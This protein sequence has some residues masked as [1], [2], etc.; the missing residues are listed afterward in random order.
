QEV[1]LTLRNFHIDVHV[2]D[3]FARTTIDQTYFNN[4]SFRME[5]TFYFPLPP[6]ASLSRLAMYVVDGKDCKLME[7]GMAERDHA[8][9][10]FE[11]IMHQ[12][13]D[14][15]LL[16]WVDGSTFKMR[17][18]PL[19][20]RQE[21]RII[22][23]YSQRL[24]GLY[25]ATRYRFPA[26]H[27]MEIVRDWSFAARVKH[28]A[29]LRVTSD[30]HP[31]MK[32]A[33]QAADMVLT[34]AARGVKP[35]QDVTVEI[36][37]NDAAKQDNVAR[38][39]SYVHEGHQYLMLNYRPDLG[40]TPRRERRDWIILFETAANRDPLLAR[41]QIEV[42]KNLLENA[43]HDDN[44]AIL[45]AN[46][47]VKV[48]DKKL[49]AVNKQNIEE[50]LKYLDASHLIGAL[51]LTKALAAAEPFY[52]QA[53]N[54]YLVHV[55]AGVS[56]L[57]EPKEDVLAKQ[58]PENV[59]YVGIG[60]GKRWSRAFMKMAADRTGG[61]FT[62]I[63]P[64]EPIAWRTFELLA[65]LNTP[66]WMDV[67]VIDA[68]EKVS[69]LT[70]TLSLAQGE[71]L[72]AFARFQGP[73]PAKVIV[74]GRLDGKA[75]TQTLEVKGVNPG[76]GYLPRTWAKMEIDRLLADGAE[77][78]KK[79]I[80]DLSMAMY[81]MSPFTSLLVLETEQD[82]VTYKVDRGRKDHWAMYDCPLR[83]PL[84]YEPDP[85]QQAWMNPWQNPDKGG[86][87]K[88]A[89]EVLGSILMRNPPRM[90]VWPN[91][92]QHHLP[93]Y[94][95]AHQLY[96]GQ[97]GVVRQHMWTDEFESLDL[98][99]LG[100]SREIF[101][102]RL[103]ANTDALTDL[104]TVFLGGLRIDPDNGVNLLALD[105]GLLRLSD[106]PMKPGGGSVMGG[107][108]FGRGGL[109]GSM[110]MGG[111]RPGRREMSSLMAAEPLSQRLRRN[112]G[113][114][115]LDDLIPT[116]EMD[117]FTRF[118][119]LRD[120]TVR[121]LNEFDFDGE[122]PRGFFFRDKAKDL[123]P[124]K[125]RKLRKKAEDLGEQDAVLLADNW[126]DNMA[127]R[128]MHGVGHQSLLY[129]KPQLQNAHQLFADLTLFAPGLRTSSADI[130]T[131]LALEATAEKQLPP[132]RIDEAAKKLIEEA[133]KQGWKQLSIPADGKRPAFQVTFNGA[134]Q[135]TYERIAGTGLRERV[136]GDG[137]S[138]WH[139]Y[140]EIGLASQRAWSRF[141]Y[142]H[143]S[144]L[145]PWFLPTAEDMARGADLV[146]VDAHTVAIR[147]RTPPAKDE[148]GKQLPV[149]ETHLIFAKDGRLAERR[150]VETPGNEMLARMT[151][152]ENGTVKLISFNRDPKGSADTKQPSF[153]RDPKGSADNKAPEETVLAEHKFELSDAQAPNL[154]PDTKDLLVMKLPLRSVGYLYGQVKNWTGHFNNLDAGQA[155]ELF[156]ADA[157]QGNGSR[158]LQAFGERFHSKG[159][160]RLGFY[161]LL[162]VS[163]S[164]VH[165]GT[166]EWN[167]LK[168][169]FDPVK[170][171][172]ESALAAWVAHQQ[173][174]QNG[175]TLIDLDKL[176]G[177]K[178]GFV[179]RLAQFRNLWATWIND[180][181]TRHGDK[182]FKEERAKALAFV[183]ETQSPLFAW[184]I[185]ESVSRYGHGDAEVHKT[186]A[187]LH[188]DTGEALGLA[189]SARY[190]E[191][192]G[193]MSAGKREAA[194]KLFRELYMDVFKAGSLPPVD[195]SFREAFNQGPDGSYIQFLR[196]RTEDLIKDNRTNAALILAWQTHQ[197]G[198]SNLADEL[199]TYVMAKT[200]AKERTWAILTGV[201]YLWQTGQFARADVL[202]RQIMD[203]PKVAER[204]A[205]WR[206]SSVLA[207]RR[208]LA[209]RSVAALEKAMDLEYRQLPE[210]INLQ[211]VRSDYGGLLNHYYQ[212]ATALTMLE[213]EAS[214]D[215]LAKVVRA[216]DRWRSLD[217]DNAQAC[218]T[219]ARILQILGAKELA[220]DYVT[221]P[222]GMKPNEAAP[223]LGLANTLRQ[224]GEFDLADRAFAMAFDAE[225]TNAE[226]LWTRASN[227][228][229]MGRYDQARAVYEQIERGSWQP[230]FQWIQQQSRWYLQNR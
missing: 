12:R 114:L 5:G 170:E 115:A 224:D 97:L 192:R 3:G 98:F 223:W 166:Y 113:L 213:S 102:G 217:P 156:I 225:P 19:E 122:M 43:E 191:A 162:N 105:R 169:V 103:T 48:F 133:R 172:P 197:L 21:K 81:V 35:N 86:K 189:Y 4:N 46:T 118:R 22:L 95:T 139:L 41:A 125:A 40:Q 195:H 168:V 30:S 71:E 132:G 174:Y 111:S 196:E 55:G 214:A 8:R 37:D 28:G 60:V 100:E 82:Y 101:L 59:R 159:D 23:S 96:S 42:V 53:K 143:L 99:R 64:D 9:N 148:D 179:Q 207:Q 229:Q 140:P 84:V 205:V 202:L 152:D 83:I 163:H 26:G 1:T 146:A 39:H 124:L 36:Y 127:L 181:P 141:H 78:N 74:S 142:G 176:A 56:A 108:G 144:N 211:V 199:F 221:T 186:L 137:K 76:A 29:E 119:G 90:L 184:A 31:G 198:D 7:G 89:E 63:N 173:R 106:M 32:I 145:V 182:K 200:P 93:Q 190:E 227:L 193:L 171:H 15:A 6:D 112:S 85:L 147:P 228:Q 80:T 61:F 183:R 212:L 131:A 2:E 11:T 73:M 128:I 58:I 175:G 216:A 151:F 185:L 120:G 92:Q 38:F 52:G 51:D 136:V 155:E 45:T 158:A 34:T 20:G 180:H 110:A 67:R 226:I 116:D 94:F 13:R 72:C 208:G 161:V 88:S 154:A 230:R 18:F 219:T 123:A 87:K 17:V 157:L 138:L 194:V 130:E 220:W 50:A 49:R 164:V 218:Q 126:L 135:F 27:N 117:E 177:P 104:G 68:D 33:P 24:P 149:Y 204:P 129:S 14:P 62:Q 203:D 134:G 187:Q 210:V 206:L 25:G 70:E 215:F 79:A 150:I 69:F 107:R 167:K 75:H 47:R 222:I 10:V 91:Q 16:E 57:G 153:N 66:R 109:P 201:E 121:F 77:K 178:D 165:Q 209:A 160:K 44:F 65:T 188:K 54:P